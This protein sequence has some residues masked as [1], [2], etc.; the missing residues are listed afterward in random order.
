MQRLLIICYGNIYRSA[1]VGE[2]LRSRLNGRVEVRSAGFHKVEGRA[3]PDSHV[4]MSA[5]LGVDLTA[6]RS[7]L[8]SKSDTEWADTIVLMD[9]HNWTSLDTLGVDPEKCVWLGTL[10]PGPVEIVDPYKMTDH[11]ARAVIK[12]L[13]QGAQALAQVLEK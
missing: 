9:R 2:Y 8:V 1:F 12:R 13:H 6:H 10:A 7:R 5:E 3:S 11:A 4:K